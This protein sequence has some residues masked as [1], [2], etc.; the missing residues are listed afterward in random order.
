MTLK[1]NKLAVPQPYLEQLKRPQ[2]T[3]PDFGSL[4][5]FS[6]VNQ[7]SDPRLQY[8]SLDTKRHGVFPPQMTNPHV[9]SR[10]EAV[11][12][13]PYPQTTQSTIPQNPLLNGHTPSFLPVATASSTK[14]QTSSQIS[15][16]DSDELTQSIPKKPKLATNQQQPATHKIKSASRHVLLFNYCRASLPEEDRKRKS[17]FAD[18]ADL[19]DALPTQFFVAPRQ[20]AAVVAKGT[21]K[22]PSRI[23]QAPPFDDDEEEEA[24]EEAADKVENPILETSTSTSDAVTSGKPDNPEHPDNKDIKIPSATGN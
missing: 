23:F 8:L 21:T 18:L 12:F 10:F 7:Y 6:S 3:Y 14:G 20:P 17:A 15:R 2:E 11:Q 5:Y 1:L 16:A 4:G 13:A 19:S 22:T 24:E 9:Q